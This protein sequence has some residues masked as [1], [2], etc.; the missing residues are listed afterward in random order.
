MRELFIGEAIKK[1]R[2]EL[3]LT[4]EQL[5]EG[6]CE[7]ITLSRLENGR[8][9]PS[10]NRINA[11][12]ERLDLPSDRYFALLSSQELEVEAL[13]REITSYNIRFDKAPADEKHHIRELA[14]NA[15]KRLEAIIENDDTL[16]RQFIL[17]S[18]VLFGT[19]DGPYS[20]KEKI[21]MLTE[22]IRL[23]V[24]RFDVDDIGRGLYTT[25]EIKII[26][27]LANIYSNEGM[28]MDAIGI[29]SQLHKY[30]RKH[31]QNIPLAHACLSMVTY[32]Y[33]NEL[34]IIGQYQN[35]IK[36]AK[37]GQ[38]VC[39]DYGFYH[40]LPGLLAIQAECYYFIEDDIRSRDYY[41]QSYY[42]MKAVG[43]NANLQILIENA[44]KDIGL[45]FE[46]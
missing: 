21:Q 5:C 24:P 39:L 7:P 35:S 1:R 42:L 45:I 2:V 13:Q 31:L 37:E 23:T 14:L 25:D 16:S 26:N 8:Q 18:R 34:K 29:L 17:R 22:A 10:R 20:C 46:H 4:Q 32:N 9:T 11:L 12:L 33:A 19:E 27:Q 41:N 3:G 43:D 44:R 40:S 28:S 30:I 15:H 36:I 6:I 38:Q